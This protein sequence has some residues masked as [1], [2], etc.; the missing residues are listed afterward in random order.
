[1][2]VKLEYLYFDRRDKAHYQGFHKHQCYEL[3]YYTRG[4]GITNIGGLSYPYKKDMFS[5]MPPDCSHDREHIDETEFMVVG[6]LHNLPIELKSGVFEDSDKHIF[7]LMNE[8]KQ[9]LINQKNQYRIRIMALIVELMVECDR[10]MNLTTKPKE[11]DSFAY[12]KNYLDM[13]YNE[14]VN[15]RNMA[16]LSCY[17]YDHFRH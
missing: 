11:E 3:V 10:M 14:K 17:S 6:F 13:H 9:E 8:M 1:M 7:I 16:M 15:I 12:I 4:S 5:I 2:E